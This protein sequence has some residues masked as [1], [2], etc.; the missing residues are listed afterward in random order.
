MIVWASVAAVLTGGVALSGADL[1]SI[2]MG[3]AEIGSVAALFT[4]VCAAEAFN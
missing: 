4:L 3:V 1:S 2:L